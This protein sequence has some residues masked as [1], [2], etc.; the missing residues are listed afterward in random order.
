MQRHF[1]DMKHSEASALLMGILIFQLLCNLAW[2]LVC[3]QT[4]AYAKFIHLDVLNDVLVVYAGSIAL[5]LA[6]IGLCLYW[7]EQQKFYRVLVVGALVIYAS[8]MLF[9][10]VMSGLL[11]LSLGVVLAAAPM[12]GI[13]ILPARLVL[14][15][16]A[17]ASVFLA[18]LSYASVIGYLPYAPLFTQQIL[19]QSEDYGIF[20]FWS[21]LCFV[22]PFLVI[23][24]AASHVFL[25]QWRARESHIRY[26]SQTDALTGIYN[27]RFAHQY[28]TEALKQVGQ[29]PIGIILLDLDHFKVMNDRYGHLIGDDILR[30]TANTLRDHVRTQDIVARFGGEAFVLIAQETDLASAEQVAERCRLHIERMLLYSA[31][32]PI[33]ITASFGVTAV[34]HA[35]CSVDSVLRQA[36]HALHEAKR[37]GRNQVVTTQ[38]SIDVAHGLQSET[39][40]AK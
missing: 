12:I 2:G 22:V 3:R 17:I 27:R 4:E 20:Y 26:M 24:I 25:N 8:A 18:A 32:G 10:G 13:L 5:A 30:L 21:Q 36:D 14:A 29:L 39:S 40:L 38:S 23:I 31:S 15:T 37:L 6:W 16:T 34:I 35:G 7:R 28:L 9:A 1:S 19:G 11:T 33:S